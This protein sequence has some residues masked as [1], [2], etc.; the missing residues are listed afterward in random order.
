MSALFTGKLQGQTA[1]SAA[2]ATVS[3][4]LD[5]DDLMRYTDANGDVHYVKLQGD[6][7]TLMRIVF[8]GASGITH[9]LFE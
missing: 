6:V 1:G 2:I 8:T 3:V 5:S 7:A 4:E 9:K